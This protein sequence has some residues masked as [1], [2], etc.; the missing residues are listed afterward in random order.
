MDAEVRGRFDASVEAL[1]RAGA[2]IERVEI[3]HAALTAAV[4][5]HIHAT[6]GSE[7][8]ARMLERSP[9]EYTPIVRLRL[10]MGRYIQSEDYVRAQNA[11][12][13]LIREVDAALGDRHALLLPA[14]PIP[15]PP[16][17]AET[18]RIDGRD[19][20]VRGLM[21]RCTQ[22]F[23]VTGHPA[24]AMPCGTTADGLPCSLQLVGH[25]GR[26]HALAQAALG[27]ETAIA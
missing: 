23:N 9:D 20:P 4:Y 13:V 3:P 11:R 16:I 18:L 1:K 19:E 8:H 22:L 10:E 27:V 12:R 7:Y 14:M 5:I 15:A 24:I 26:T 21:L 2:T 6:E 25:R 17:G